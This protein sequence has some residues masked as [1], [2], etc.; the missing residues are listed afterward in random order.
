MIFISTTIFSPRCV[1]IQV[2]EREKKAEEKV[3]TV[4]E[5][6]RHTER[7][8]DKEVMETKA[9]YE[10][11]LRGEWEGKGCKRHVI[12]FIVHVPVLLHRGAR[13]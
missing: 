9:K 5:M 3:R 7:D 4:E 11:I 6:L 12:S 8:A 2:V 13:V 10:R 1:S